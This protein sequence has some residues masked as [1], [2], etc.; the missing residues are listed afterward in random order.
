MISFF[1]IPKPFTDAQTSVAQRNAIASWTHAM[2][3]AEVIVFGDEPGIAEACAE[4][5]VRHVPFI[6]RNDLG[7]PLLSFAFAEAEK[8]AV[9]RILCYVNSDIILTPHFE[10]AVRRIEE[11][12]FLLVGRRMNLDV[13]APLDFSRDWVGEILQ[14]ADAEGRLEPPW[15]SDYFAFAKGS[16]FAGMPPF[17]VG[18]P[19][20]DN[21]MIVHAQSLRIPIFDLTY[22]CTAVHQN[23]GYAHVRH[24]RGKQWEGL[25][26]DR[27][28]ALAGKRNGTVIDANYR[29]TT[30]GRKRVTLAGRVFMQAWHSTMKRLPAPLVARFARWKPTRSL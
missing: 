22:A 11:P 3:E 26:G 27:N 29:L 17:A 23:H 5:C 15:G 8:T 16:G 4:L 12:R 25:E 18:R 10:A 30:S 6:E 20:W 2:P 13:D 24:A 19:G 28:R 14:R 7:T 21:W 9:H 1:T